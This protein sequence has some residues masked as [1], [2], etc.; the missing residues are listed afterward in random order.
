[1]GVSDKLRGLKT[2]DKITMTAGELADIINRAKQEEN[3]F[4]QKNLSVNQ[5]MGFQMGADQERIDALYR[6]LNDGNPKPVIDAFKGTPITLALAFARYV[7][8]RVPSF[9]ETVRMLFF[10]FIKVTSPDLADDIASKLSEG[11]ENDAFRGRDKLPPSSGGR[12]HERWEGNNDDITG[13]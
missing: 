12:G 7:Q 11:R 1:M 5:V 4:V 2:S 13:G 9:R 6:G 3:E 10:D 8:Q